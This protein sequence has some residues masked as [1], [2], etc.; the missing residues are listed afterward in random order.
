[1]PR[2]TTATTMLILSSFF[3]FFHL[4]G[5]A[6][7]IDLLNLIFLLFSPFSSVRLS[8]GASFAAWGHHGEAAT[9]IND[10]NEISPPPG[11]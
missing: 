1:M 3:F 5:I 7:L 4:E 6:E 9:P 2:A 11:I 8:T 10:W